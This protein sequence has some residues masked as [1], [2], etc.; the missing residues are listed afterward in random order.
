MLNT[1][2]YDNSTTPVSYDEDYT[3]SA[4]GVIFPFMFFIC[5]VSWMFKSIC[6]RTSADRNCI[7]D[8]IESCGSCISRSLHTL[9]SKCSSACESLREYVN[10]CTRSCERESENTDAVAPSAPPVISQP[11]SEINGHDANQNAEA[12]PDSMAPPPS[13]SSIVSDPSQPPPSYEEVMR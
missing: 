2:E 6:K 8:M 3:V 10:D 1:T 7:C 5:C 13:Y 11:L 9:I 12:L 4:I